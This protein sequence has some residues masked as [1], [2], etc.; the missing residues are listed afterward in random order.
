MSE[1]GAGRMPTGSVCPGL[2][3]WGR[4]AGGRDIGLPGYHLG[5]SEHVLACFIFRFLKRPLTVSPNSAFQQLA[6]RSIM[7][8]RVASCSCGQLR[9]SVTAEPLRVTVCHCRSCQRR[10]GSAFGVQARFA[11]DSARIEGDGVDFVRTGDSGRRVTFTFCPR[12]GATVHYM[13]E[14]LED[15]IGIPVGAFADSLFPAPSVAMHDGCAYEWLNLRL[16]DPQS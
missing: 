8:L 5:V 1:P 4:G 7:T 16:S 2:A 6:S 3:V 10:T 11:R 15:F 12:C 14:G 9:A 13:L